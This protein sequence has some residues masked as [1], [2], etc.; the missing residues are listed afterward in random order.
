MSMVLLSISDHLS[1]PIGMKK[2][3]PKG[4]RTKRKEKAMFRTGRA[5]N[6]MMC[7]R[8]LNSRAYNMARRIDM[9]SC[10]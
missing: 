3:D 4:V 10:S 6:C 8:M 7:M 9:L 1:S 2:P 5:N